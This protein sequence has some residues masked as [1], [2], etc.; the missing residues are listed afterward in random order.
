MKRDTEAVIWSTRSCHI[1]PVSNAQWC[2]G[3]QVLPCRTQDGLK[4]VRPIGSAAGQPSLCLC[5]SADARTPPPHS[6]H[7]PPFMTI[8]GSRPAR[9]APATAPGRPVQNTPLT[10]CAA[11]VLSKHDSGSGVTTTC[12]VLNQFR[13]EFPRIVAI[14]QAFCLARLG[15]CRT[16]PLHWCRH[17]G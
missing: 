8:G 3:Y 6:Q 12:Q 17:P 13:N 2:S 7:L 11:P 9:A 5:P 16:R 14:V 10:P 4:I 15:P 1:F